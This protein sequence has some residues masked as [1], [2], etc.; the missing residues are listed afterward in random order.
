ML[1]TLAQIAHARHQLQVLKKSV[2]H[3]DTITETVRTITDQTKIL[4]INATIEAME[5]G[6]IGMGFAVVAGEV[7][8]LSQDTAHA[9]GD[10]LSN[11]E[12][13]HTI[14]QAFID[15]FDRIDQSME[16]RP[17]RMEH[18]GRSRLSLG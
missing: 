18:P 7:K 3:V 6:E 1:D 9:T 4:A 10:I 12:S 14:C 16:S 5:A 15:C 17:R 13:M 8:K 11:I 2:A